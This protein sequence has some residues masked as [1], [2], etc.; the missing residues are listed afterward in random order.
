MDPANQNSPVPETPPVVPETPPAVVPPI[1]ET[2]VISVTPP[3]ADQVTVV[4]ASAPASDFSD[5]AARPA[6]SPKLLGLV[7]AVV[8]FLLVGSFALAYAVAAE[9]IAAPNEQ[10]QRTIS[11]AVFSIPFI[12]KTPGYI[13]DSFVTNSKPETKSTFDLSIA[14]SSNDFQAMVGGS[15]FDIRVSGYSDF[16][17][18]K[19]PLADV[20]VEISNLFDGQ[21][22]KT[23]DKVYFKIGK[24][25]A[26]VYMFMSGMTPEI[27][28]PLFADWIS[29]DV[30]TLN[31]D[32]RA[33]LNTTTPAQSPIDE[34]TI[35]VFKDIFSKDVRPYLK[36]SQDNL[37]GEK[38]YKLDFT[39]TP[40]Q[41]DTL[42]DHI[43]NEARKMSGNT[44]ES[45]VLEKTKP[46]DV[47]KNVSFSAWI[48]GKNHLRKVTANGT[49][50][51]QVTSSSGSMINPG[52]PSVSS[53]VTL[54]IVVKQSDFGKT[55]PVVAPETSI[56]TE[57][58]FARISAAVMAARSASDSSYFPIMKPTPNVTY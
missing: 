17:D 19:N 20:K 46:S 22:R 14:A 45:D 30:T 4:T 54:A 23:S 32:A 29:S 48:D 43:A 26:F 57:E 13:V 50:E 49:I 52:M 38:V 51:N 27:V 31:T 6:K 41:L 10:I 39:P 18:I 25:P 11:A 56:T 3:V 53:P 33:L 28:E 55:I 16:S 36:L 44:T 1:T 12:P 58:F 42:I 34:A 24:I 8:I 5:P 37:D 35:K 7:L 21:L 2:P 47:L 15:N 40:A 9:K